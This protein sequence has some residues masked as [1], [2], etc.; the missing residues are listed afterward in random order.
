MRGIYLLAAVV[1]LSAITVA[2]AILLR[3]SSFDRCLDIITADI[4][5]R[6]GSATLDPKDVE[7]QAAQA[8]SGHDA[9]WGPSTCGAD[10]VFFQ[11]PMRSSEC[12]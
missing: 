9:G 1:L 3:P 4:Y 12:T 11:D 8:C 6:A 10:F 2:S 7:V 5:C